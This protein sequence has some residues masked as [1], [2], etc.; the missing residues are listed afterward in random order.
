MIAEV[1]KGRITGMRGNPDHGYTRGYLCRKGY[2]YPDRVY[3]DKRILYPLRKVNARW[4]R[5]SWDEALDVIADKIR[6]FKE[7][8]GDGSIM[9]YQRS[10]SWGATKHLV[11]RFFN[12]LGNVTMQSGSLCAGSVMA[13]QKADMGARLGNDPEE[14]LNSKAILIWGKDPYKSSIHVVPLLREAK[15][16]G[17]RIAL[18]DPLRTKSVA[19]ADMYIAPRPGS[20]GFLALGLAKEL[21]GM[22]LIDREFIE[23]HTSGFES[24]LHLA[25]S[26]TIEEIARECDVI[27]ED[28]QDLARLYGEAKPASILLG[29]GINKWVHSVEMIRLIDAVGALTGNIGR[30]GGGVNHGFLTRRHFDAAVMTPVSRKHRLIPEPLLGPGIL[31][32]KDPAVRMIWINGTN[33]MVSCPDS[34]T[35]AEALRSLD[36][37]VVVDHFM[38]DT[39]DL[40]DIFLPAAT[41][42]EEDDIL[43]SWGHNWIG[44]VNKAI[45]PLGEAKSDLR[46]VQELADRVGLGQEMA[47]TA[48]EWLKRLMAPMEKAGL[49]VERVMSS[50]VRC[51]SAP[52]V[53]FPCGTFSTPSKKFEFLGHYHVERAKPRPFHL[54]TILSSRWLNSLVLENEHP[55]IPIALIHPLAAQSRGIGDKS[56]A[57]IRTAAGELLVEVRLT[58]GIRTDAIAIAQGTWIKCGGGVNKLT[59]CLMS[60]T[61]EMAA[62]YS[63]T[64][65][66]EAACH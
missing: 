8:Y 54:L 25:E 65:D 20:D 52:Q 40:A 30:V 44:P 51:P 18:I 6:F 45:E 11:K 9:H 31:E 55:E 34:K 3:S 62:Y 21:T 26:L 19:L 66:I 64:A 15:K 5:I 27:R 12:L 13:A 37:R 46:I 56:R 33:P 32:S 58:E 1:K 47:G 61:G 29:Y 28:I 39:A 4:K 50:P 48:V 53:A 17:A 43:V 42:L 23:R 14:F 2:K 36:F 60:P 59:E 10:A 49:T 41:F 38:T 22:G 63:T 35:V 7:S 24:Y 57:L 16:R